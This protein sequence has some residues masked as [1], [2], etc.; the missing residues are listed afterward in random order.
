MFEFKHLCKCK[1]DDL[2]IDALLA[3]NHRDYSNV[4][5]IVERATNFLRKEKALTQVEEELNELYVLNLH[6]QLL[7]SVS[8]YWREIEMEQYYQSWWNLQD[9]LDSIRRIKKFGYGAGQAAKFF[10]EQLS[11]LEKIYPYKLFS[12]MGVIVECYEC[13]I[14]GSDMDSDECVHLKGELYAGEMALA[15]AKNIKYIDHIAL[16]EDPKNKRLVIAPDDSSP[17]FNIFK[18][19]VKGFDKQLKPLGFSRT[20]I[21][22]FMRPNENWVKLGRNSKCFCGSGK[23]YKKCCENQSRM[24]Q[25]HV[26]FIGQSIFALTSI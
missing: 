25:M 12:S 26:D 17:V 10:E 22:E 5:K 14:C 20:V 7:S 9:A 6:F 19:L 24:K 4:I 23:K 16:V 1:Y 8:L 11:S 3:I 15:V 21:T 2:T 13:S 18:L